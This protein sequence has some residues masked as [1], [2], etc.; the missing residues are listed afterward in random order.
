MQV[1]HSVTRT[2][3]TRGAARAP[4]AT[5]SQPAGFELVVGCGD[6]RL[7][8]GT[9][10]TIK[11][12]GAD[13]GAR[14]TV[15]ETLDHPNA[16]VP[17]HVHHREDEA[18]YVLDGRLKIR[19]GDQIFAAGPGDFVFAPKELPHGMVVAGSEPLRLLIAVAP[20]GFD[21]FV[22]DT[23]EP[24]E[25]LRPPE[26]VGKPE[27]LERF[28]R[29]AAA[30]GIEFLGGPEEIFSVPASDGLGMSTEAGS[31]NAGFRLAAGE[32]EPRLWAGTLVTPKLE[33]KDTE[34]RYAVVE[35]IDHPD[36]VV[37]LHVHHR[38][39][40]AFWV[41]EGRM[42]IRIGSQ[43]FEVEPGGFAF[44]PRGVPHG[45]AVVSREPLRL[46]IALAPAG[47]EE[48]V[49]ETSQPTDARNAPER[50]GS[51]EDVEELARAARAYGIDMLGS[52][53]DLFEL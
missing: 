33:G 7:W 48:F 4:A 41:L 30:Y 39:D 10:V 21:Q 31:P 26:P 51:P 5:G 35:T 20:A 12:R 2:I 34:N 36:T 44:G 13:S 40:E 11:L 37:P 49:R 53:G 28:E 32:G 25:A 17:L 18:F 43:I 9:L 42:K 38:E 52:P 6:V 29:A 47:F 45:W 16:A 15:I 8:D 27:D 46:L 24:T 22:L 50:F 23:S 14:L 1:S 19:V 3:D